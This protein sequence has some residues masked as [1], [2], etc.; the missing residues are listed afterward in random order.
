MTQRP[1]A[2]RDDAVIHRGEPW[3]NFD[4]VQFATLEWADWF[5]HRQ[6]LEPIGKIPPARRR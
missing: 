5:N 4:A 3:K 2:Q 1:V 6:L